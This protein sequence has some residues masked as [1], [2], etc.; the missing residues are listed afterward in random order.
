M[1]NDGAFSKFVF[2]FGSKEDSTKKEEKAADGAKIE[3]IKIQKGSA[4]KAMMQEEE[5][6]TGSI[7]W[8]VYREYVAAAHGPVLLPLFLLSV[9]LMQC[10]SVM[11]SYW[12]VIF[13]SRSHF[14]NVAR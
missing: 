3:A 8:G 12:Y 14:T 5:R 6:N 9:I 7:K 2:E 1:A 10:S 11:S 4:G 13:T